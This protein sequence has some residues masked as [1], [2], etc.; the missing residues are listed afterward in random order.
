VRRAYEDYL[1]AGTNFYSWNNPGTP[2]DE[3]FDTFMTLAC[4]SRAW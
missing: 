2:A 1:S 3:T 4:K